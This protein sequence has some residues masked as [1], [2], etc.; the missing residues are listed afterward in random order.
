MSI[1]NSAVTF[2]PLLFLFVPKGVVSALEARPKTLVEEARF[3]S[4]G[5]EEAR[6]ANRLVSSL[7]L[8]PVCVCVWCG[9]CVRVVWCGVCVCVCACGVVCVC[10]CA[11][12]CVCACGVCVYVCV[13]KCV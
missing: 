4:S 10:V 12:L 1:Q 8:T 11:C 3:F 2:S 5:V 6:G 9:V 7:E 13:C